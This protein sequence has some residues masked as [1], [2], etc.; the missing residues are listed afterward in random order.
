[1]LFFLGL[2]SEFALLETV[3]TAIYDGFP[4]A[5]AHKVKL[6]FLGCLSCFL[7]GLPCVS[8]SGQYV[9]NLMDTYGAGFAVIWIALWEV[10]GLM[11]IYGVCNFSKDISLMIGSQPFILTKVCWAFVCPVALLVIFILSLVYWS[12]PLYNQTVPYPDWAHWLGWVLVGISAV[13]VPLWAVLMSLVYLCKRKLTKVV[14]P[15][16]EWGPGDPQVRRAIYEEQH[17]IA[18]GRKHN[19]SSNYN[20]GYDNQAISAYNM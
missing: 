15:T 17:N 20:T 14:R 4:K 1:M 19:Y 6:T 2:D 9:L 3:L 5:R 12:T 13:Q 7:L 16:R 18:P 8:S 10:I 11:W